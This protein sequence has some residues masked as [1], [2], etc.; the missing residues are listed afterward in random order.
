MQISFII[1]WFTPKS[2]PLKKLKLDEKPTKFAIEFT[3]TGNKL[4]QDKV[5]HAIMKLICVKE[6][7]PTLLDSDEWKDL[8][9]LLN[10]WYKCTPST[11]FVDKIIPNKAALVC[12]LTLERLSKERNLTLTFDGNSTQ[13]ASS[14][15]FMHLTTSKSCD[16]YL[17]NGFDGSDDCH[18]AE[19]VKDRIVETVNEVG[20]D[21]VAAVCSDNTGNTRCGRRNAQAVIPTMLNLADC[22]HH[23]QN[24]IKDIN[25]IPE[26]KDAQQDAGILQGLIKIG[27]TRFATHWS[28]AAALEKNLDLI[29]EGVHEG[30]LRP[31]NKEVLSML[32][33]VRSYTQFQ[34]DIAEYLTVVEPIARSL[35]S[36][37][38]PHTNAADVF[39]FWLAIAAKLKQLF[40]Q[41]E[42]DSG[43]QALVARKVTAIINCRYKAFINES[44]TD[45]YFTAFFLHPSVTL[46]F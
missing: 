17:V 5:N 14:I 33:G 23:L 19:W 35:W 12:Q 21:N 37:E 11:K 10:H 6:L 28:A 40:S 2:A 39:I 4:L 1:A 15:Y 7:A 27:K 34:I 24:T 46:G 9:H 43:I 20:V 38:S 30:T 18:T 42:A 26:F 36:L 44:P 32:K 25:G 45:I 3:K 13:N 8:M 22:V 29:R 31:K 41:T 16:S